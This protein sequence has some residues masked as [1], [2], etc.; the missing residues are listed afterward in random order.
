MYKLIVTVGPSSK[1][2]KCLKNMSMAGADCFRI[3]L[4]HSNH[5]SFLEYA[6]LINAA[7]LSPSIDTQGAQGRIIGVCKEN[8]FSL[9]EQVDILFSTSINTSNRKNSKFI[10]INH[11]EILSQLSV[12]DLLRVD[13]SGLTIRIKSIIG[14]SV[15]GIIE[16]PGM[17]LVNRAFDIVDKT[18]NL[19]HLTGFD[20]ECIAKANLLGINSLFHSFT[21]SS[22]DIIYT[23]DLMPKGSTII[24]KIEN[25]NGLRNL[26]DIVR[27][28]DGILI[29]RGDLSREISISMVPLVVKR[30]I[31]YCNQV[32]KPVYVATNVLDSMMKNS[33]PSRAE[34]SDIYNLLESG[35]NAL[36][37]AAE[38]AIGDRP[39]NSCK[40][41]RHMTD[42]VAKAQVDRSSF[43]VSRPN[44]SGDLPIELKSWL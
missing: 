40:V 28:S 18:L 13:F 43:K 17:C 36:V 1:S 11:I 38:V 32:D 7:G 31:S 42:I 37:L 19:S 22:A 5:K 16:T 29:D 9:G 2:L 3:N 33:L 12:N 21:S 6:S 14:S 35:V 15:T 23:R 30:I 25:N 39:V 8:N 10:I 41:I 4:S 44:V 34:I 26:K 20:K 24:A 27:V